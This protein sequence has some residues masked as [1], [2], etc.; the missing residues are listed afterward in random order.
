MAEAY[1][2]FVW[3]VS[4]MQADSALM[5]AATG[6]V[7]QDIAPLAT[8]PPFVI[9]GCQAGTDVLTGNVVR[10]WT[11]LIFQIKAMGPAT[12]YGALVTI[13]DRIDALFKRTGPVGLS[14]GT[15][16]CCYREQE[17]AISELVNG[18]QWSH[19]GGLYTIDL[20]GS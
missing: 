5:A 18:Q 13:A 15:V 9:V 8:V 3:A 10:L 11:K 2:A 12:N 6:G 1:Q 17:L 14:P 19:L 16:L 4:T 20:Q 7:Y